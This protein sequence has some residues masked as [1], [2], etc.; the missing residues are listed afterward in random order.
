MKILVR[1]I[2]CFF[3][4]LIGVTHVQSVRAQWGIVASHLLPP[5]S[6]S[7][8][9]IAYQSGV[10]WVGGI[11]LWSSTNLGQTWQHI[12]SLP[13]CTIRDIYFYD[14]LN[15]LV[16]TE[17]GNV[18]LTRDGGTTWTSILTG[19]NFWN[20]RFNGSAQIIHAAGKDDGKFYTSTDA[21]GSWRSVS[22]S[23]QS[24]R[25]ALSRNGSIYL[26]SSDV[27]NASTRAWINVSSDYGVTWSANSAYVD[28]DSYTI[29][30]DSC[31]ANRWYITNEDY[32]STNDNRSQ[33]FVTSDGGASWQPTDSHNV[34]YYSGSFSSTSRVLYAG[35][36]DDRAATFT[37]SREVRRSVDKGVTWQDIGGPSV[38]W[39]SRAICAVNDN[40][41]FA[42][43]TIGNIW[44]TRNSGGNPIGGNTAITPDTLFA[45][46]TLRCVDSIIRVASIV[47]SSCTSTASIANTRLIGPDAQ[48]YRVS[49]TSS[50]AIAVI[51]QPTVTG[52]HHASLVVSFDDGSIDTVILEGV[53]NIQPG[54]LRLTP[55]SLFRADTVQCTDSVVE[56]IHLHPSG[57]SPPAIARLSVHGADSASYRPGAQ[58]GDSVA[59][60][61]H[62]SR[63][64]A[65]DAHLVIGKSDGTSDTVTLGGYDVASPG[66]FTISPDTLFTSDTLLCV[67]SIER[68]LVFHA[69]GCSPPSV[70]SWNIIGVD[71]NN[72]HSGT[73]TSDSLSIVF[74]S[75]G[76]GVN[77][78]D[79][80]AAIAFVLNTGAIDTVVLLGR[81][82]Y[83]PNVLRIASDTLFAFDTLYCGDS[84]ARPAALLRAGCNPPSVLSVAIIGADSLSYGVG[85]TGPDSIQLLFDPHQIGRS[86]ARAIVSNSDGSSDTIVLAGFDGDSANAI[87]I[88]PALVV[89]GSP[90][91]FSSDT[92]TCG[93]SVVRSLLVHR[94]GCNPPSI[95][96]WALAGRDSLSYDVVSSSMDSIVLALRS[97]PNPIAASRDR[98]GVFIAFLSDGTSDTI[99]LD[100]YDIS[101]PFFYSALPSSL[102]ATDSLYLCAP[103][104]S[105]T[106]VWTFRG[107][108]PGIV[109]QEILGKDS[110]DYTILQPISSPLAAQDSIVVTYVPSDT[111][112]RSAVLRIEFD[113]GIAI[114]V[115]LDGTG[116]VSHPLSIITAD[117]STDTVGGSLAV[118]ITIEGLTQIENVELTLHY[119]NSELNYRGSY[120]PTNVKLDEPGEQWVGRSKILIPNAINGSIAGYAHFDAFNDSTA[121]KLMLAVSFDSVEV[122]TEIAPCEYISPNMVTSTITPPFGCGIG[123]LSRFMHLGELPVFSIRPN[124]TSGEVLLSS[125]ID[126]GEASVKIYDVLGNLRQSSILPI[127]SAVPARLILPTTA[128]IYYIRIKSS[129][130]ISSIKAIVNN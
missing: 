107:C 48:S 79:K 75:L 54:V 127:S 119:D 26:F 85:P 102:F 45:T 23:A 34:P 113:N 95:T 106:I 65:Y 108:L 121:S 96:G 71:S 105:R 16:G 24:G 52:P 77:L 20:V 92:V 33:I 86:I 19:L 49:A 47:P 70:T 9:A 114:D 60:T 39:D 4:V 1:N 123:M 43:D 14:R 94:V 62:P 109:S 116:L 42:L 120:S 32:V 124:P 13:T 31:D 30:V 41:V 2:A 40:T 93:D 68:S 21:G 58:R 130:G 36:T 10:L 59:V 38:G 112:V 46:D 89:S 128:G 110:I 129:L 57:C 117:A 91:L 35:T 72:Y 80:H 53:D 15:G 122:P 67:D 99:S 63:L 69:A 8:G 56:Y 55:D 98:H 83:Q 7:G 12:S 18:Y 22:F 44:M 17:E 111:G 5:L 6:N 87:S 61:F 125:S 84:L 73:L 28:G 82:S 97:H 76:G 100:G 115:P 3:V 29:A 11:E 78:G 126:L 81:D 88:V 103:P 74:Q 50:S 25:F 104:L 66:T 64:G 90:D 37:V 51:F 27:F 101:P 118:P